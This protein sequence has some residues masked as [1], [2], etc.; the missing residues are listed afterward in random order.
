ME[1]VIVCRIEIA[2][3][4]GI[5]DVAIHAG[6][7]EQPADLRPVLGIDE[8]LQVRDV[9][10]VAADSTTMSSRPASATSCVMTNSA[11]GLLQMFP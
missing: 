1:D 3:V 8:A 9:V 10:A 5:G 7:F 6:E 2:R 11:I 4:P